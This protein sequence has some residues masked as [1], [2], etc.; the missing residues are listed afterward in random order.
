MSRTIKVRPLGRTAD[1]IADQLTHDHDG[2]TE[3]VDLAEEYD[4]WCAT[5]GYDPADDDVFDRWTWN[6]SPERDEVT[7]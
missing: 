4:A 2:R 3:E 6:V 1:D 7:A 5:L